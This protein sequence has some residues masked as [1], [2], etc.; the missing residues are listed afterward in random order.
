M[1]SK[2]KLFLT[3]IILLV[4]T[5]QVI[6]AGEGHI[7]VNSKDWRDVYS[8]V[9]YSKLVGAGNNFVGSVSHSTVVL[10]MISKTTDLL[11]VTSKKT[12][13]VIG[14]KSTVTNSGF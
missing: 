6:A 3:L 1:V 7:L 9:L 12:P 2:L 8:G 10:G 14:Y 5:S 11:I 13:Y 4:L